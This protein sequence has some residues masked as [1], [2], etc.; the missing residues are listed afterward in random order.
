MSQ[1]VPVWLTKAFYYVK[2][3]KISKDVFENKVPMSKTNPTQ[4]QKQFCERLSGMLF[5]L[6]NFEIMQSQKLKV[7]VIC[8][9][10]RFICLWCYKAIGDYSISHPGKEFEFFPVGAIR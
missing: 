5:L 2:L 7:D 4:F 8:K 1:H 3:K 10:L 6:Q 9:L